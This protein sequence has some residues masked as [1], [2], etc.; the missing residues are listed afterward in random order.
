MAGEAARFISNGFNTGKVGKRS[1]AVG[2][3]H[4]GVRRVM[5]SKDGEEAGID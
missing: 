3:S 1:V 2:A 5:G 4:Y